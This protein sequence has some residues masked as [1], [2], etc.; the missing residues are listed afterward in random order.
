MHAPNRERGTRAVFA[1]N[2]ADLGR[3]SFE[4]TDNQAVNWLLT[5]QS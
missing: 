1:A 5:I 4:K 3:G 2:Q